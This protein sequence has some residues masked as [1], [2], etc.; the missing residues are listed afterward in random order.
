VSVESVPATRAAGLDRL[1]AFAPRAGSAYAARRNHDTGPGARTNVSM[2]SPYLRHRL[3]TEPEV[4]G[5]VLATHTPTGAEKFLQ[6]V[7]WRTY[8]KGW[9]EMRP[10]VWRH[11]DQDRVR[12]HSALAADPS[13]AARV[14]AA[15]SGKTGLDCFDSWSRELVETGYLHNHT[16]MWFASIWVYTLKLPWQLGADFFMRHLLDGDPASNTLSW[17]WVCGLQTAGK[18]YLARA[19]NIAT[20]T[21]GRFAPHGK[22]A[23][24]APP[25]ADDFAMPPP[26]RPVAADQVA[27]SERVVLLVGEDDLTPE[28]WPISRQ[29]I[30]GVAGLR[31][32]EVYPGTSRQVVAFKQA[33]LADAIARAQAYYGCPVLAL[34]ADRSDVPSAV[35]GLAV[36]GKATT[37]AAMSAPVGPAADALRPVMGALRKGGWPVLM[38]RRP[39]D[40]AL[41]PHATHGFFKLK[42]QIPAVLARLELDPAPRLPL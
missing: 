26:S 12:L 24:E 9:L 5:A 36:A 20:Y 38:L 29:Q 1:A 41:W 27:A 31:T 40:D 34:P 4:V 17:R 10:G 23:I 14:A 13:F 28:S 25:L 16:R 11:F 22:L 35:M 30:V 39:W 3:V 32:A 8:W 7:C 19:D 33:A 37:L 21:G 6:E 2:L 18:T 42:E 15:E